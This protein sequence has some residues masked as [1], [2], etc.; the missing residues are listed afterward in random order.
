MTRARALRRALS[1]HSTGS[2]VSHVAD[3]TDVVNVKPGS[4]LPRAGPGPRTKVWPTAG[5]K[6][7]GVSL[8]Q[9]CKWPPRRARRP[10]DVRL[11]PPLPGLIPVAGR[12]TRPLA[13]VAWRGHELSRRRRRDVTPA[14]PTPVVCLRRTRANADR[15]EAECPGDRC[16]GR[17]FL[18]CHRELL[19]Q[20]AHDCLP[21]CLS[22]HSAYALA[23]DP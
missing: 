11:L 22:S 1:P 19:R 23:T 21:I 9:T 3:E 5:S 12:H 6:E 7:S 18:E 8:Y 17:D 15:R 20:R 16:S 13:D 4:R 2:Q 14:P 10:S